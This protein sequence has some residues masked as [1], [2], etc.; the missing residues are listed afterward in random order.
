MRQVSLIAR[1]GVQ[2]PRKGCV[3]GTFSLFV[4]PNSHLSLDL[5]KRVRWLHHLL[6]PGIPSRTLPPTKARLRPLSHPRL[7]ICSTRSFPLAHCQ[8][9]WKAPSFHRDHLQVPGGW[10]ATKGQSWSEANGFFL[11]N[12]SSSYLDNYSGLKSDL[13]WFYLFPRAFCSPSSSL[14]AERPSP[15]PAQVAHLPPLP[16]ATPFSPPSCVFLQNTRCCVMSSVFNIYSLS[17]FFR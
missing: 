10:E 4:G 5:L 1:I 17:A 9:P 7:F 6:K 2:K 16:W 11:K 8:D 12:P 3:S 15:G 13:F 14:P